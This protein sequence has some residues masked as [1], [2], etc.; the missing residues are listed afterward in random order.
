MAPHSSRTEN[1]SDNGLHEPLIDCD[2]D[3][4]DTDDDSNI[5]GNL[6]VQ[7]AADIR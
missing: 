2:N 4:Y 6:P 3:L 5:N 7:E 1:S